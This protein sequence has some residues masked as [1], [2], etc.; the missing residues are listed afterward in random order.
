MNPYSSKRHL[1]DKTLN[2]GLQITTNFNES[3]TF[4]LYI[5]ESKTLLAYQDK[6]YLIKDPKIITN[7]KESKCVLIYPWKC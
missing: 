5:T 6:T 1:Q 3:K 2:K 4:F 7:Y